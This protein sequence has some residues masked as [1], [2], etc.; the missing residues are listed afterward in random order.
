MSDPNEPRRKGWSS[1]AIPLPPNPIPPRARPAARAVGWNLTG[2]A[3]AIGA[4]SLLLSQLGY[5]L[6]KKNGT[7]TAAGC[8]VWTDRLEV[9]DEEKRDLRASEDQIQTRC[10]ERVSTCWKKREEDR[11]SFDR[12]LENVRAATESSQPDPRP[13]ASAP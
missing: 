9:C 10:D 1:G 4:L 8:S 2:A 12:A 5:E 13:E 6:P 7:A 3:T 11:A